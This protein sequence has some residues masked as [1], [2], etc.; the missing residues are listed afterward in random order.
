MASDSEQ[1]RRELA[2]LEPRGSTERIPEHL[3]ALALRHVTKQRAAG[4]SWQTLS[5]ELGVCTTTLRR[6]R[7]RAADGQSSKPK[8]RPKRTGRTEILAPVPVMVA[9]VATPA[10]ANSTLALVSPGGYRL[11]GLSVAA[12]IGLFEQLR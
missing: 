10:S 6:W 4:V 9:P 2:A 8:L 5:T 12:A 3:R 11:E 1:F 7:L